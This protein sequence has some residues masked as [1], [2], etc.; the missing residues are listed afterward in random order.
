MRQ[1]AAR[2]LEELVAG[3]LL[4]KQAFGK[5]NFFINRPS[6]NLFAAAWHSA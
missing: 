5:H 3:G 2:Y 1:T 4:E 6:V